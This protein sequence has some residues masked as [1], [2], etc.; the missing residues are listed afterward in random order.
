MRAS[1]MRPHFFRSRITNLLL[2]A[3][4][5]CVVMAPFFDMAGAIMA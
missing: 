3:A 4:I 5:V 2:S 1:T